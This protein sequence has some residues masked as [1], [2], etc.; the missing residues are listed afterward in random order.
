MSS[1]KHTRPGL[2]IDW[3]WRFPD[4][5][6]LFPASPP[7]DREYDIMRS[8]LSPYRTS[9]EADDQFLRACLFLADHY[10]SPW[11]K[12][13]AHVAYGLC[14]SFGKFRW[15]AATG[16]ERY[17]PAYRYPVANRFRLNVYRDPILPPGRV[18]LHH[19]NPNLIW[20]N[21]MLEDAE[22][23]TAEEQIRA[24]FSIVRDDAGFSPS[25]DRFQFVIA[26]DV[27]L[28]EVE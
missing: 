26:E 28:W 19:R 15:K 18:E 11:L 1:I 20:P 27:A 5:H 16:T 9:K 7:H 24:L 21:T 22:Y 13:Q 14:R 6:R 12:A 2:G 8:G 10:D 23:L 17:K 25:S 4:T 3:L